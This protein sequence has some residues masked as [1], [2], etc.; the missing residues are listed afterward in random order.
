MPR[1]ASAL[2]AS[3]A[4]HIGLAAGL[5]W[6]PKG[7][8]FVDEV[9]GR[10]GGQA[11]RATVRPAF[12]PAVQDAPPSVA[13]SVA[14]A[15]PH[16]DPGVPFGGT[17]DRSLAEAD[18]AVQAGLLPGA[19]YYPPDEL[20]RRPQVAVAIEP[21]FP[22]R[23]TE[24]TGRVVLR[25]L[26]NESGGVDEVIVEEAEPPGVFD[27]AARDAFA[28]ARFLPGQRGGMPVKSALRVEV[29]FGQPVPASRTP[30]RGY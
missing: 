4:V 5:E 22:D 13:T 30:P 25:L 18:A 20:D 21:E 1:L 7:Q 27:K 14:A 2:A 12:R 15:D 3:V 26:V 28:E 6:L 29:L 19:K 11:I 9:R 24:P 16:P 23:A 8:W 17:A 10:S